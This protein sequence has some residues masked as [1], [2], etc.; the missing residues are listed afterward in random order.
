MKRMKSWRSKAWD[1]GVEGLSALQACNWEDLFYCNAPTASLQFFLPAPMQEPMFLNEQVPKLLEDRVSL[2]AMKRYL[3]QRSEGHTISNCWPS[4]QEALAGLIGWSSIRG[5]RSHFTKSRSC[6][7][8]KCK[9]SE[10]C[11]TT[12][13][14]IS[15]AETT[16]HCIPIEC[17][18]P[19]MHRRGDTLH[20][21]QNTPRFLSPYNCTMQMREPC[22]SQHASLRQ[23]LKSLQLQVIGL[24]M[25]GPCLYSMRHCLD[26]SLWCRKTRMSVRSPRTPYLFQKTYSEKG[27]VQLCIASEVPTTAREQNKGHA[28]RSM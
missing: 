6:H 19:W 25:P 22:A 23:R 11:D 3:A 27:V 21:L 2:D 8:A 10:L 17:R 1:L 14:W 18:K 5:F 13:A 26:V 16:H 12:S 9:G 20:R 28:R 15:R 4:L 24:R 7:R